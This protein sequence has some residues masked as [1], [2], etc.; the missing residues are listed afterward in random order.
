MYKFFGRYILTKLILEEID[1]LSFPTSSKF[2]EFVVKTSHKETPGQ[3]S[4]AGKCL[5]IFEKEIIPVL[6]KLF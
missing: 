1:I 5:Q 4:F 2:M 3:D 6:C